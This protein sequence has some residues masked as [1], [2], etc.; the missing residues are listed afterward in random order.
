MGASVWGL[1]PVCV[2]RCLSKLLLIE[3]FLSQSGHANGF[4]P[5]CILRCISKLFLLVTIRTIRSP[6]VAERRR[7]RAS[8]VS[9]QFVSVWII[10]DRFE[11]IVKLWV[12]PWNLEK[13]LTV[14]LRL[15]P[16]NG[17]SNYTRIYNSWKFGDNRSSSFGERAV[18]K[19]K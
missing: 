6:S 10:F 17:T 18:K 4:S 13:R 3:N 12:N 5:E 19:N 16:Q 14:F 2:L 7:R 11:V 1:S 8:I 9:T 15:S